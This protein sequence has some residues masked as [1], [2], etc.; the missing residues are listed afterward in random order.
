MIFHLLFV[1]TV[2]L[3]KGPA[4]RISER[5]KKSKE[6]RSKKSVKSSQAHSYKGKKA[7]LARNG[8]SKQLRGKVSVCIPAVVPLYH[9]HPWS[10]FLTSAVNYY[11]KR[12]CFYV[13]IFGNEQ[14]RWYQAG[15]GQA[16]GESNVCL[17][18]R[19]NRA[20][21]NYDLFRFDV[22]H[23]EFPSEPHFLLC[24]SGTEMQLLGI[25]VIV[26]VF[27]K[28]LGNNRITCGLVGLLGLF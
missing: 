21:Y 16:D 27:A 2:R 6:R 11:S 23:T 3:G 24:R 4:L 15:G 8:T 17:P 14:K 13:F 19:R 10:T 1:I 26:Q 25:T 18:L 12:F 9:H 28:S 7:S 22:R 20:V 5:K